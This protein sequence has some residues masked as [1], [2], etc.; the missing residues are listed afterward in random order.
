[1]AVR[2][3]FDYLG[4]NPAAVDDDITS[5]IRGYHEV[6]AVGYD[7]AGLIIQNSWGTGWANGGFGRIS[8]RVVQNDVWE[9]DIIDGF[10]T[11]ATPT[12]RRP[13][14]PS[15][16]VSTKGAGTRTIVSYKVRGR[17][18]REPAARSRGTRRCSRLTAARPHA[19]PLASVKA[20][21]FTLATKAGH[22]YKIGVRVDRRLEVEPD[23]LRHRLRSRGCESEGEEV[24]AALARRVGLAPTGDEREGRGEQSDDR[25]ARWR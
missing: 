11:P 21:T 18:R 12:D 9:A 7:A 6:L 24:A 1:M 10:V 3:G 20:T 13:R 2:R 8:W 17:A 22:T 4:A 5:A 23:R 25:R 15:R 14:R 19:V 16:V